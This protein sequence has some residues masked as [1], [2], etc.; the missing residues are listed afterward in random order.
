MPVKSNM[1]ASRIGV[2]PTRRVVDYQAIATNQRTSNGEMEM[3]V[4]RQGERSGLLSSST[5]WGRNPH[6]MAAFLGIPRWLIAILPVTFLLNYVM[7]L[8]FVGPLELGLLQNHWTSYVDTSYTYGPGIHSVG[9]GKSFV[10]FPSIKNSVVFGDSSAKGI[11]PVA[12][13]ISTRTG[14]DKNEPDSGGQPI[15]I[16]L[17]FQYQ[18]PSESESTSNGK[19]NLGK[20]Y[21]AFGSAY[22]E[23][24]VL[25]ARNIISNVAQQFS[26]TEFWTKR[27]EVAET[28]LGALQVAIRNEGH[29]EVTQ[30]Q[31]LRID[32]PEKYEDM[33]TK[34]QLQVQSKATKEYEQKVVSVLNDLAVLTAKNDAKIGVIQAKA[35]RKAL[36]TMNEAR[37]QGVVIQQAAKANATRFVAETLSL[38]S[39]ETVQYLKIQALKA[40]PSSRT[41]VGVNGPFEPAS[42]PATQTE[43]A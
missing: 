20:I 5:G 31:L 21:A 13:P 12:G 34:I 14:E 1:A 40:H 23:R 29:A 35:Q 17:S 24:Y 4:M 32:F 10:K 9:L 25:I 30:L 26:P 3:P 8:A 42:E 41:I 2:D 16:C 6:R 19:S 37:Q 33:I 36:T 27:T 43:D 39:A 18:L 7:G 38:V 15:D 11:V 22:Q 28:M